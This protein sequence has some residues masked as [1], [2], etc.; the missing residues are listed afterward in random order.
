MGSQAW[1]LMRRCQRAWRWLPL[2]QC[3]TVQQKLQSNIRRKRRFSRLGRTPVAAQDWAST[4]RTAIL[5]SVLCDKSFLHHYFLSAP[6]SPPP[7]SS[8][9][10]CG[11]TAGLN[12][13][14]L[15]SGVNSPRLHRH[16][17]TG[18]MGDCS[19]VS[20]CRACFPPTTVP[21]T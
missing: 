4:E 9:P 19:R 15:L 13:F 2:L 17:Q 5:P 12:R 3:H 7:H 21:I 20:P 14:T 6:H 10:D 1:V 18:L 16:H 8:F 11:I